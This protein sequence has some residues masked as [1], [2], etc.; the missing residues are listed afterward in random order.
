[1]SFT[2]LTLFSSSR[3]VSAFLPQPG[4]LAKLTTASIHYR[5]A[6][7]WTLKSYSHEICYMKSVTSYDAPAHFMY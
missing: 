5:G 4:K 7:F 3:H 6:L 2:A 1:M